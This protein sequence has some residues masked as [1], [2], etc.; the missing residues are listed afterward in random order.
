M[1][2]FS[3]SDPDLDTIKVAQRRRR[4]VTQAESGPSDKLP[5]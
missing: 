4:D 2:V 5:N 3:E 1:H